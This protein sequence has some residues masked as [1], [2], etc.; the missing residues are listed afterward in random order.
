MNTLYTSKNAT[1]TFKNVLHYYLILLLFLGTSP[2]LTAQN[3]NDDI[4]AV[5]TSCDVPTGLGARNIGTTTATLYWNAVIGATGY[6]VQYRAI[7]AATAPSRTYETR[8]PD[9]PNITRINAADNT[10]RYLWSTNRVSNVVGIN[11]WIT[12]NLTTN[13]LNF[14]GLAA[15]TQYE[16][17][18][19]T[20]CSATTASAFSPS[21]FF[22]TTGVATCATAPTRLEVGYEIFP[23]R[24]T[25]YW[26][27][28]N[29]ARGY[30]L[31][32][33]RVGTTAWTTDYTV[34]E[35]YSGTLT[36]LGI[37]P[38]TD[39]E[40]RVKAICIN[41]AES[42]YS[43]IKTFRSLGNCTAPVT[44]S[45]DK[46]L[47]NAAYLSWTAVYTEGVILA[48]RKVGET[49]WLYRS[50]SNKTSTQLDELAPNTAYECKIKTA[51][52]ASA[53]SNTVTF[54]TKTA[55]CADMQVTGLKVSN[56]TTT[57]ATLSWDA[58]AG[59]TSYNLT[60]I[61]LPS[62]L[63][64][65]VTGTS[66]NL[67]LPTSST[68]K[69]YDFKVIPTCESNSTP[70]YESFSVGP[71]C[72]MAAPVL[73]SSKTMVTGTTA[74]IYWG[75]TAGATIYFVHYRPTSSTSSYWFL[76][77]T[78]AN[79]NFNFTG[80][81]SNT[82]Y[83]YTVIACT[84]SGN[85]SYYV[86][87]TFT[88]TDATTTC[89][90]PI[91]TKTSQTLSS[92]KV[93]VTPVAGALGYEVYYRKYNAAVTDPNAG[94]I[95]L[96]LTGTA[97]ITAEAI[98]LLPSTPYQVRARTKCNATTFTDYS[99]V[100]LV[101]T[102]A[103][104]NVYEF[105]MSDIKTTSARVNWATLPGAQGYEVEYRQVRTPAIA[106][107]KKILA[108]SATFVDITGLVANTLY[109]YRIRVKCDATTFSNYANSQFR[110]LAIVTSP[111]NDEP[112]RAT[113][114]T[115]ISSVCTNQ[116]YTTIGAT[117]TN[118]AA[119][120]N[121]NG[122]AIASTDK[123]IWF[124]IT[125]PSTR[126]ATMRFTGVSLTNYRVAL[127]SNAANCA[128]ITPIL[129]QPCVNTTA[130]S[131]VANAGTVY[132][133]RLWGANGTSGTVNICMTNANAT[134]A[135]TTI[136]IKGGT[137]AVTTAVSPTSLIG[138]DAADLPISADIPPLNL[139][140]VS[141]IAYPNPVFQSEFTLD[142]TSDIDNDE[143]VT[144]QLLDITGRILVQNTE[145]AVLGI[146]QFTVKVPNV[147]TGLYLLKLNRDNQEPL[148]QKIQIL[149]Y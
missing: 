34:L 113:V 9:D 21:S 118:I 72:P 16:F 39:Y 65:V 108:A 104:S 92:F 20:T 60:V 98:G 38:A 31:E 121:T 135:T 102:L 131:I 134:T 141:M 132:Y 14:A 81:L 75:P 73:L 43:A 17:Q 27:G 85:V 116:L 83:E 144:V 146:N 58:V 149:K 96:T 42:A 129:S 66:Y 69:V 6:T 41:N 59:A 24:Q 26:T 136:P 62:I 71:N 11:P 89:T 88:T 70:N 64:R 46:I 95:A 3:T 2:F 13:S 145:N 107:T 57:N 103:C 51:C 61:G 82:T 112:C 117:R 53:Y 148:I 63:T 111:V 110:T 29:D 140:N 106:Y 8:I 10:T 4:L 124:K 93:A 123:D 125:V 22:T 147:A 105:F 86:N 143:T 109:D 7:A 18:V 101:E 77:G 142:Y 30:V 133:V 48:Y 127:Y 12:V 84:G 139:K 120:T 115:A 25:F 1:K 94:W 128:Y 28:S 15:S 5:N 130:W 23:A 54:T 68:P 122:C 76:A 79:L 137:L 67:T 56:L 47:A 36:A 74:K 44:L 45:V 33:R 55:S 87:N 99:P 49:T 100:L 119:P 35:F 126:V 78:T 97:P 37:L 90:A 114:L 52:T 32:W 19:K 80:L 40:F 91:L 138:S 50:F